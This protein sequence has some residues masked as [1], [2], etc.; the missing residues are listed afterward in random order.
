MKAIILAAGAS[1]RLLPLTHN[2][3]KCL[4][5]VGDKS[6]LEHQLDAVDCAGIPHAV[7]V[8][9]YL[10]EKIIDC[11][12]SDYGR[13]CTIS[14][15]ENPEY[16]TTNTIYSLYLAKDEFRYDDFIYFNADV[17][18]HREI[19]ELL[20][21]HPKKN[22]LAVDYKR[23]GEEEVKFTTDGNKR[24]LKLGKYIPT[25]EAEGEFIGIAKFGKNVS[26]YFIEKLAYYSNKGEKNLFFEKA[27]EDI[28]EADTFCPLDVTHIPNIEIDF[29]ED[30]DAAQ[31]SVY[32]GIVQYE[33][34]KE[35]ASKIAYFIDFSIQEIPSIA[36]IAYETGGII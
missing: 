34:E 35:A 14:Y 31:K 13:N 30:L 23:C 16:E 11:I 7:I 12:G 2:L 25:D 5:T 19:V 1:K 22:V 29:P 8:V 6:I 28:L 24:I 20:I 18:F 33:R 36:Y 26:E 3:P 27:V 17:L 4:I 10:K 15:I 21:D 9:G 32:P